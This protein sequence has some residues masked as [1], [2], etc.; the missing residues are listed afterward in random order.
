MRFDMGKL[1]RRAMLA[2]GLKDSAPQQVEHPPQAADAMTPLA[3]IWS[4][5]IRE[6]AE[7]GNHSVHALTGL[8]A[9]I[10]RQ[11]AQATGTV[12]SS[13]HPASGDSRV[14]MVTAIND[15][16]LRLQH[17]LTLIESAVQ[18]NH[19]LLDTVADAVQAI[20]EL[21][22]TAQSVARISQ[23][24][25]LLSINARIEA[26]RAGVAGQ[27]FAVVA[28]EVR[29]LAALSRQD[30][31]DILSRVARIEHLIGE[32]S[33]AA[34]MQRKRDIE[35]IDSSR[36]EMS[37]VLD[38]LGQSMQR[39]TQDS[40]SL[41][42]IGESTRLTVSD[43]LLRFQF[44]DRVAQ[45]LEHVLANL[46]TWSHELESGWPGADAVAALDAQLQASYT[47]PEELELHG[48]AAAPAHRDSGGLVIF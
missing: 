18:S 23:M 46:E 17:V 3:R 11:L 48:G 16:R 13:A 6:A 5:H 37:Q 4:R 24:T 44:Q 25:T 36:G 45:R 35:L 9:G 14:G 47:L 15:A 20:R 30:S 22:E 38:E 10:E 29:K 2:F 1:A 32:A 39:M 42:A 31:Q 41:Y 33:R 43:A 7:L 40:D 26:A 27:G 12:A 21:N 8:F 19:A 28:D 34:D